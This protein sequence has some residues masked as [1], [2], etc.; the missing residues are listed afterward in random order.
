MLK[1]EPPIRV[2]NGY[3]SCVLFNVPPNNAIYRTFDIVFN[4]PF[5]NPI[6]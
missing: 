4:T 6:S 5:V 3:V 2:N 1:I